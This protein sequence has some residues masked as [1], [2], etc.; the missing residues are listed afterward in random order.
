MNG[1]VPGPA[2]AAR[3]RGAAAGHLAILGLI[4]L[5]LTELCLYGFEKIPFTCSYL[6]GKS[7]I[8]LAVL[9][10]LSL[11]WLI[12]VSVRYERQALEAPARFA[13]LLIA[14]AFAWPCTRWRTEAHARSEE[15]EV[16]FE[17]ADVPA[18]QILGLNRDGSWPI[19][20]PSVT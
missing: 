9:G 4:A 11:L 8:H 3:P 18:I 2:A 14:L 17:E 15:A 10:A 6:P 12:A 16:Q 20:P 13:V 19:N 1:T 5:I 7:Q